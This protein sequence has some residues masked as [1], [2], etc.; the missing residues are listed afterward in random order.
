M[1]ILSLELIEPIQRRG[2]APPQEQACRQSVIALGLTLK[3]STSYYLPSDRAIALR[4][5]YSFCYREERME[6]ERRRL[7]RGRAVRNRPVRA[8]ASQM[9]LIEHERGSKTAPFTLSL[10]EARLDCVRHRR[11]TRYGLPYKLV[12]ASVP[13]RPVSKLLA[14]SL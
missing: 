5:L 7:G 3:S 4:G 11:C 13:C 6:E 12:T 1:L 9:P 14:A 2:I 8:F 10:P